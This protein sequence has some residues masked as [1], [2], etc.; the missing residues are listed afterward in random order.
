[1][2]DIN[3]PERELALPRYQFAD[4]VVYSLQSRGVNAAVYSGLE[5][6]FVYWDFK[7]LFVILP[8]R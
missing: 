6:S 5:R 1:M 7:I 3:F 2:G 4:G 8:E